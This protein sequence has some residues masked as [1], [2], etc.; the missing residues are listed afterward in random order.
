MLNFQYPINTNNTNE[1][2][3][4]NDQY[5]KDNWILALRLRPSINSGRPSSAVE[6]V[7]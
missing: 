5:P 3:I 2:P 4:S 6:W 7:A 1:C